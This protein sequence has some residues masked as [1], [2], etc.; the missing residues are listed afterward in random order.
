MLTC[1]FLG[2]RS[3]KV[4]ILLGMSVKSTHSPTT[5]ES[6]LYQKSQSTL[7]KFR[8]KYT[9][10]STTKFTR[11]HSSSLRTQCYN[12]VQATTSQLQ[13]NRNLKVV[14]QSSA[15]SIPRLQRLKSTRAHASPALQ[16]YSENSLLRVTTITCRKSSWRMSVTFSTQLIAWRRRAFY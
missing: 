4:A 10:S 6:Q 1:V 3:Y 13:F 8:T 12:L 9:E 5:S 7:Q 15:Y 11:A 16:F 14:P 2:F